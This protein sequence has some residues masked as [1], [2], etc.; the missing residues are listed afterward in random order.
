MNQ[1]PTSGYTFT[2]QGFQLSTDYELLWKLINEG[3]RV[4]AWVV[5]SAE[6]GEPIWDIVDVKVRF[7]KY[8][9]GCRGMGYGGFDHNLEDFKTVCKMTS[10]HFIPPN[11]LYTNNQL[12]TEDE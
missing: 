4:P 11:I 12:P 5:Y 10:L 3:V 6:Y 8:N 9:I 2:N 7:N 1:K